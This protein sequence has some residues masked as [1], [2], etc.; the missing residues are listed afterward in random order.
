M[1]C[2]STPTTLFTQP[3]PFGASMDE[4][5]EM[6]DAAGDRGVRT[7]V[8]LQTRY[9]P[10]VAFARDL[11]AGGYVGELWSINLHRA[12]DQ[13]VRKAATPEY[14]RFLERANAGLRIM[15]GHALDTL[16]A[17]VGELIDIQAYMEIGLKQL[18][19]T[20]GEMGVVTH[21]DQIV[22]QGRLPGAAVVSAMLKMNS[23]T[24][25]PFHLEI[26]GSG[27]ALVITTG[28]DLVPAARHPGVP[29]D[30]T[31]FGAPALGEP[32]ATLPVPAAYDRVPHSVPR[33]QPVDVAHM[34][35]DFARSVRDGTPCDTDFDHGLRRHRL[36]AAIERAAETGERQSLGAA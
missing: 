34:Y 7:L 17:Y 26:S 24:Y 9:A 29:Y 4:A 33:G 31:L 8:G 27:G 1:L 18:P 13:T 6:R 20:T 32:F 28:D 5:R 14:L 23:P 2:G 36:L 35:L 21:K 30:L 22:L 12:N 10:M 19:L 15:G 3:R 11:I 25:K 16:A